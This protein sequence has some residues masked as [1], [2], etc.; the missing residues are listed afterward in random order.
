MSNVQP[1]SLFKIITNYSRIIT[2]LQRWLVF[3]KGEICEWFK[4]F[5]LWGWARE[6]CART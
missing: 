4:L 6:R 1:N 3:I 2:Q 5:C